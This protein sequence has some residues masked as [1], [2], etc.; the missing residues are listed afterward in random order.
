MSRDRACSRSRTVCSRCTCSHCHL[1]FSS[2]RLSLTRSSPLLSQ[3]CI[4]DRKENKLQK[5]LVHTQAYACYETAIIRRSHQAALALADK[6]THQNDSEKSLRAL[7]SR[8]LL[9]SPFAPKYSPDR[10]RVLCTDLLSHQMVS[11]STS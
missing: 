10:E 2:C 5:T 4:T 1:L 3:C 6:A 8:C 7:W 11:T 9:P